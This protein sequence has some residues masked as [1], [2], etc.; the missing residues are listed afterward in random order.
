MALQDAIFSLGPDA[1]LTAAVAATTSTAEIQLGSNS[2]SII[3]AT[4]DMHIAFG[5]AGMAASSASY[6]RI[7]ANMVFHCLMPRNCD[8]IRLYNP[9][10]GSITYHIAKAER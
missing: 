8:R 2:L 4:G 9:G 5:T 10:G 6:F 7:P 1:P 3:V